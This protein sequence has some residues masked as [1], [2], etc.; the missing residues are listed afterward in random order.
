MMKLK[1]IALF[2][3]T[4]LI[5]SRCTSVAY[6]PDICFQENVLPIFVSKCSMSGCHNSNDHE[7]GY[8]FSN[9]DGIMKGV[10][11][12]HPLQSEV[13]NAIKGNNPSMPVGEK[14]DQKDVS[15]IRIWIKM[16]AQNTSNCTRCD[17]ANYSYSSRIK[18][19]M[20][21]WCVGCH[22]SGSAGGGYDL[23][24]YSGVSSSVVSNRLP[25]AL[26]HLTGFSPMPKNTN[27]LSDCDINAVLKW[28]NV[29]Y[30]N[31]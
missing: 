12:G 22:N 10:T 3:C 11:K 18:P 21:T 6:N 1:I 25:G 7:A 15:I 8:D 27:K 29:G 9:Y 30:P 20:I 31:N 17:T 5:Y 26:Q 28:I 23:S 14:L 24:T 19:L 4:A 13:Y 2:V 16:G